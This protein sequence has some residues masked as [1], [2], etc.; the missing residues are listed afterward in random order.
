MELDHRELAGDSIGGKRK[1]TDK[2]ED[3]RLSKKGRLNEGVRHNFES[4]EAGSQPLWS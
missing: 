2:E 3:H 1:A 4:V